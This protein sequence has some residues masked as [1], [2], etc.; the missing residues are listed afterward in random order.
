MSWRLA[1]A[2]VASA[3]VVLAGC[4]DDDEA[5]HHSPIPGN[6]Q[7]VEVRALDDVFRGERTVISSGTEVA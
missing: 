6:G 7:V 5:V 3:A 1:I 4:G 2:S